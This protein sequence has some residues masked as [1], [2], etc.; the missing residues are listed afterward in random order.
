[1]TALPPADQLRALGAAQ[2][3]IRTQMT[4]ADRVAILRYCGR[5]GGRPAGFHR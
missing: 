2:K 4:P 1:M 3:F 5:R